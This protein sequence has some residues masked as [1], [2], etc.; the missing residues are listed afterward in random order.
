M[1]ASPGKAQLAVAYALLALVFG[2]VAFMAGV[3]LELSVWGGVGL[4]FLGANVGAG[5]GV[6]LV[7][8]RG[9]D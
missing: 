3:S 5:L 8:L 4:A 2:V 6:L 7:L 9:R 1:Q